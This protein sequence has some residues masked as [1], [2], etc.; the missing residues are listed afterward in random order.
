MGYVVAALLDLSSPA[1][2]SGWRTPQQTEAWW[3]MRAEILCKS[4]VVEKFMGP[5]VCVFVT[6]LAVRSLHLQAQEMPE[7]FP[8]RPWA[9][10]CGPE[11]KLVSDV[12]VEWLRMSWLC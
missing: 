8:L 6:W 10:T 11:E 4:L 5:C 12:K 1:W 7:V 3:D 2:S 9:E